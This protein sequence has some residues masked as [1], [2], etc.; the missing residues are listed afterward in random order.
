MVFRMGVLMAFLGFFIGGPSW[1]N[2]E[3]AVYL[4]GEVPLVMVRI[5]AGAFL[6]GAKEDE[7]GASDHEYPQHLVTISYD[8]YI[9]KYEVTQGQWMAIMGANPAQWSSFGVGDD[10]PVYK[11]SWNDIAYPDGDSFIEK[12]NHYLISTGQLEAG[13][14]RL[15]SEAEWEYACRAGTST[16]FNFGDGFDPPCDDECGYCQFFD[17]HFWWCGNDDDESSHPVGSKLPNTWGLYD[18]PGNVAEWVQDEYHPNYCNAP[19]DGSAWGEPTGW[20]RVIRGSDWHSAARFYRS[21]NRW[22]YYPMDGAHFSGSLS[23]NMGETDA[24]R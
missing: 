3:I 21:A 10:Y 4:P 7:L 2:D 11:V 8:Y 18:M 6:M 22:C 24:P 15:P 14:F 17:N 13:K 5:E 19:C 12:L 23:A 16:R 20:Y 1:A 9:G